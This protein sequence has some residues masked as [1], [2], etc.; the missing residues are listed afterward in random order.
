MSQNSNPQVMEDFVFGGIESDEAHLLATQSALLRG[1]RHQ[2]QITPLDP[3]P[4]QPVQLTVT[5]GPDVALDSLWAHV[6]VWFD[7]DSTAATDHAPPPADEFT[8]EFIRQEVRW[9]P[10]IWAYVELWQADAPGQ[11]AGALVQYTIEGRQKGVALPLWASE[12][13]MDGTVDSPAR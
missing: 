3:T 4:G 9:E 12:P 13:H 5:V 2:H 11:P 6:Q 1:I 7:A 10:L 8:I